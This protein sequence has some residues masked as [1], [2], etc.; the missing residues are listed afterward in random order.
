MAYR[1]VSKQQVSIRL[2]VR[3]LDILLLY[4]LFA[5][6]Y[7]LSQGEKVLIPF[8]FYL[9]MVNLV[10]THTIALLYIQNKRSF[11]LD[12]MDYDLNDI[13]SPLI[14]WG[15]GLLIIFAVFFKTV[16]SGFTIPSIDA[17]MFQIILVVPSETFIFAVFLP[18]IMPSYLGR[19]PLIKYKGEPVRIPGWF[20]GAGFFFGTYHFWAYGAVISWA[21]L[22]KIFFA[23][24]MGLVFY[25]LYQYGNKNKALG[26]IMATMCL[27]F[28][29]NFF[30]L[31]TGSIW[32]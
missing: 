8:V 9:V 14:I 20:W 4:F 31:G 18:Q 11:L 17:V 25:L 29:I 22:Y 6:F 10:Y 32:I 24:M 19:V 16:G 15:F 5:G 7:L 2:K 26:G 27:H 23:M 12:L 13:W 1:E 21:M 3:N 28:I 30:A